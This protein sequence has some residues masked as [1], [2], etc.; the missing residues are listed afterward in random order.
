M[1]PITLDQLRAARQYLDLVSHAPV[2]ELYRQLLDQAE[3]ELRQ[4][5]VFKA[6]PGSGM[7]LVGVGDKVRT[8]HGDERGLLPA[9]TACKHGA[10]DLTDFAFDDE[11]AAR[12]AIRTSIRKT[13]ATWAELTA[14][15]PELAQVFTAISVQG[16]R[17]VYTGQRAVV[18]E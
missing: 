15:C 11:K 7:W 10:A 8:V 14:R 17:V 5:V 9:W 13:C 18:T 16:D 1:N 6:A 2:R 12:D 4:P 3:A